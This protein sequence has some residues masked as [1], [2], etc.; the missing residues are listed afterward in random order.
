MLTLSFITLA[1]SSAFGP[2]A[3]EHTH[4]RQDVSKTLGFFFW[5]APMVPSANAINLIKQFEACSLKAYPD[6]ASKDGL[7][8]TIGYGHTGHSVHLGQT[9]TSETADALLNADATYA[10]WALHGLKLNQNQFDALVSFVFNVG[11]AAFRTSSLCH[12]LEAGNFKAASQEFIKWNH[13][14][15]K[16]MP[17]LTKRRRAEKAL[18]DTAPNG[19]GEV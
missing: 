6:P 13:A 2:I 19:E 4:I 14:G 7:P 12:Y 8:I 9:I 18:F 3:I 10:A 17:G 16:V 1:T 15:G 11:V 5:G